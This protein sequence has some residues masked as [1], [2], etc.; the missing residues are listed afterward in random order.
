MTSTPCRPRS[1]KS[2]LKT[3]IVFPRGPPR[4]TA[5]AKSEMQP[6]KS[7]TMTTGMP[8]TSGEGILLMVGSVSRSCLACLK[9]LSRSEA[10]KTAPFAHLIKRLFATMGVMYLGSRRLEVPPCT[11]TLWVFSMS[12]L[13]P[14]LSR[15]SLLN[16]PSPSASMSRCAS[17]CS[18][19]KPATNRARATCAASSLLSRARYSFHSLSAALDSLAVVID[20]CC[21]AAQ[22]HLEEDADADL[23]R[24]SQSGPSKG[25]TGPGFG[26]GL[27]IAVV[28]A[29]AACILVTG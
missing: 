11:V 20:R 29:T 18:C 17:A 21:G 24:T 4:A 28:A 2:P 1:T 8:E 26:L 23:K 27:G 16:S 12:T 7:P 13:C 22:Q 14:C 25:A 5:W 9:S 10:A 6:C 15:S 19:Q 3:K